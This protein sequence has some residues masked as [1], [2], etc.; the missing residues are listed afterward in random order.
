MPDLSKVWGMG[1]YRFVV[2]DERLHADRELTLSCLRD[3][4]ALMIAQVMGGG[5]AVEIYQN[6]RMVGRHDPNGPAPEAAKAVG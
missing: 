3:A 5:A 2:L 4:D 1:E 6:S